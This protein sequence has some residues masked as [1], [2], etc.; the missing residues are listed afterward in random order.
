MD[1]GRADSFWQG[2]F[3]WNPANGKSVGRS[4]RA[5]EQLMKR[6][7]TLAWKG[8]VVEVSSHLAGIFN[9]SS[10]D[11]SQFAAWSKNDLLW[12]AQNT[13][14]KQVYRLRRNILCVNQK[15]LHGYSTDKARK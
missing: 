7:W 15:R 10:N 9:L 1:E 5:E 14:T 4:E 2:V 8:D 13:V 6:Y 12:N 11:D 3:R